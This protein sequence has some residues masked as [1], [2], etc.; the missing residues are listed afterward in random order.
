[1]DFEPC[2]R[3]SRPASRLSSKPVEPA[4]A[5]HALPT[6]VSC[7]R[8]AIALTRRPAIISYAC[9]GTR[10]RSPEDSPEYAPPDTSCRSH[11]PAGAGRLLPVGGEPRR[12]REDGCRHH[13]HRA[14]PTWRGTSPAT[15]RSSN[16]SPSRAP[17]STTTSRRRAT[18]SRAQEAD[19]ILWNGL[20]LELW[21]EKFF[22]NLK[23]CPERRGLRRRRADGH[24]RGTLHRQAQPACL[25]VAGSR[26]SSMSRT[27]ARPSSNT[28]RRM[29][30]PTA[31]NAEA[32]SEKIRATVEPIRAGARRHSRRAA[33]AG[34]ERRR[35]LLSGPRLRPEGTLSLADQRRPAGH[36]A[37][38]PQ[39]DRRRAG[40]QHPGG[41]FSES[42]VSP[43]PAKQVARETGAKYGGVLYVD[44][45][46]DADG[47]V[48]TYLDLLRSP[49]KPSRKALA[50]NLN[51][52]Q[53][54]ARASQD[55]RRA[56]TSST[57]PS[58]TA[59]ATPR[60][61]T[62]PSPS[63]AARSPRWSASTAAASRRCSR[64]SWASCR[65]RPAR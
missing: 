2:G 61:A 59:T 47:P 33:L 54:A 32:Y 17:R 18:L 7:K 27:S 31:A 24:R 12:R 22:S 43:D 36:A 56:V 30:K 57:S 5:P 38:G 25:D 52:R 39:G 26:R 60:C 63:R 20:N 49:P 21:F 35:V 28:I 29:P 23:R 37:A 44:S 46:S 58:P 48:P 1:M 4:C 9:G 51:A 19:L 55:R 16:R 34:V 11:C 41:L 14:S 45:L 8:F 65:W 64:R 40:Q 50:R 42:T 6:A 3:A 62:R 10:P 53:R 15:R 13:L